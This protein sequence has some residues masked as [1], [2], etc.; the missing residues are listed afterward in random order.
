MSAH[1]AG[2]VSATSAAA[3]SRIFR[4]T[5]APGDDQPSSMQRLFPERCSLTATSAADLRKTARIKRSRRPTEGA[6]LVSLQL[7][8]TSRFGE[9]PLA[10]GA[11]AG[12]VEPLGAGQGSREVR[13]RP[14]F[15]ALHRT[16]RR[17]V[18]ELRAD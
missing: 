4:M 15:G 18:T 13:L 5:P 17:L 12:G 7:V 10:A 3:P 2:I 9:R 8:P 16:R 6:S 14:L 1:V 11:I